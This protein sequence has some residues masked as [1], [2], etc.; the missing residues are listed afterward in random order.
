[1]ELII[2]LQSSWLCREIGCRLWIPASARDSNL[3]WP[4]AFFW[5]SA[6]QLS[7]TWTRNKPASKQKWRSIG[8]CSTWSGLMWVFLVLSGHIHQRKQKTFSLGSWGVPMW[9]AWIL[10]IKSRL[11]WSSCSVC[12]TFS[13]FHKG[14]SSLGR[15]QSR[16]EQ[17]CSR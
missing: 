16:V 15:L 10:N 7:T 11:L 9:V 5:R 12:K 1:M 6:R 13:K 4:L 2:L 14:N 8:S 17:V 3:R